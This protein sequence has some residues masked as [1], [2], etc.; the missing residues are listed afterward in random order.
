MTT[1]KVL[2]KLRT[3]STPKDHS[4]IRAI[5][6]DT[7]MLATS[8]NEADLMPII[9][10]LHSQG[11]I[12]YQPHPLQNQQRRCKRLGIIRLLA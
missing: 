12:L 10:E 11:T 1:E 4:D 8:M 3:I 2:S 6:F 5:S 7:L 9:D